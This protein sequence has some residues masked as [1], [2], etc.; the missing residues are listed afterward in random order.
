MSFLFIF[1]LFYYEKIALKCLFIVQVVA[2]IIFD[3]AQPYFTLENT[4]PGSLNEIDRAIVTKSEITTHPQVGRVK[5][6]LSVH[7]LRSL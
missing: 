1:L 4:F 2:N 5:M 7:L 3:H 6:K